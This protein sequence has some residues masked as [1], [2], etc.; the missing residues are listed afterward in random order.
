[1]IKNIKMVNSNK[2]LSSLLN[3]NRNSSRIMQNRKIYDNKLK[4]INKV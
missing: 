4:K 3:I 2:I 1:M